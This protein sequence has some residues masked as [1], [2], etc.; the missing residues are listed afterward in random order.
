MS[1]V[2][3]AATP[4]RVATSGTAA[5]LLAAATTPHLGVVITNE[6]NSVLFVRLG[7]TASTTSYSFRVPAFGILT[8]TG[9]LNYQ[10]AISGILEA[11]SGNA[12]VQV[13]S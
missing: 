2:Q 4:A 1:L 9:D 3:S 12:E 13:L 8:L 11:G 5:T 6:S 7:G 10:G